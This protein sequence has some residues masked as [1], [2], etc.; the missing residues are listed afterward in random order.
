MDWQTDKVRYRVAS[1]TISF[2]NTIIGSKIFL[3]YI[4]LSLLFEGKYSSTPAERGGKTATENISIETVDASAHPHTQ[5]QL[6]GFHSSAK[7]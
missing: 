4:N 6:G 2:E 1:S 5:T 7:N 3:F